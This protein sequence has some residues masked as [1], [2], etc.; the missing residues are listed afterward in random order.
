MIVNSQETGMKVITIHRGADDAP[1]LEVEGCDEDSGIV[2][3]VDLPLARREFLKGSG[4]LM[5]TLA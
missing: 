5:G 3:K 1:A 4:I 2:R